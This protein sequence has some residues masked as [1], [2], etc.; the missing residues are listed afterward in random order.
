MR[1]SFCRVLP[2][3]LLGMAMTGVGQSAVPRGPAHGEMINVYGRDFGALAAYPI[4]DRIT[5][6]VVLVKAR[7][8]SEEELA[9]VADWIRSLGFLKDFSTMGGV[10]RYDMNYYLIRNEIDIEPNSEY[11]ASP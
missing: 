7:S 10:P 3:M 2:I 5:N 8:I 1:D 4:N 11:D 6:H 9:T